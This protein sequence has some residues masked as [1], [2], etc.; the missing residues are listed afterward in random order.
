VLEQARA[1]EKK[2]K[3]LEERAYNTESQGPAAKDFVRF[4]Q[5]LYDRYQGLLRGIMMDY[6]RAPTALLVE[7]HDNLYKQLQSFL[8][9]FNS[10]INTDVSGFNKLAAENGAGALFTGAPIQM[11]GPPAKNKGE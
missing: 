9:D 6:D 2:V 1:L 3:A 8:Q 5:K 7:E 11:A 10:L 4:T